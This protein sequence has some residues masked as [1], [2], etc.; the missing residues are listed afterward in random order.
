[1]WTTAPLSQQPDEPVNLM[2]FESLR[3]LCASVEELLAALS[4]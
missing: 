2:I 4:A 1:M 3:R